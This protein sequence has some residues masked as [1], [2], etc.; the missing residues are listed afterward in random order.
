MENLEQDLNKIYKEYGDLGVKDYLETLEIDETSIANII[1]NLESKDVD[2]DKEFK[3]QESL[4]KQNDNKNSKA[5][6]KL[7]LEKLVQKNPV[8]GTLERKESEEKSKKLNKDDID[9]NKER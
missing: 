1:Y 7:G 4:E 3:A 9:K 8:K 2:I 6:N 5:N